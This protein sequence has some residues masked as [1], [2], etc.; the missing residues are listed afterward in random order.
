MSLHPAPV[1]VVP[2]PGSTPTAPYTGPAPAASYPGPASA[3]PYP[4]P[5]FIPYP[6]PGEPY[7]T[8]GQSIPYPVPAA[9]GFHQGL[10]VPYPNRSA[11]VMPQAVQQF[12]LNSK[13]E[14]FTL[15]TVRQDVVQL[16][17]TSVTFDVFPL[18]NPFKKYQI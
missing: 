17:G 18:L 11:K 3:A 4:A 2:H 15:R 9:P 16:Q 7:L 13:P 10:S 1:P 6:V 12:N 8:V 14:T 5:G